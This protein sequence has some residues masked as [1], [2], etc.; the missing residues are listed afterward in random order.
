MTLRF[1]VGW[2][3]PNVPD[4]LVTVNGVSCKL[5]IRVSTGTVGTGGVTGTGPVIDRPGVA[6]GV[7]EFWGR[8]ETG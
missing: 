1:P 2:A 6:I 4:V 3:C 7:V 8:N 5:L